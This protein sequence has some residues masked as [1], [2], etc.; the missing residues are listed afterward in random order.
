MSAIKS[1]TSLSSQVLINRKVKWMEI[2]TSPPEI[3]A[4]LKS[5]ALPETILARHSDSICTGAFCFVA[6]RLQVYC[7]A[8]ASAFVPGCDVKKNNPFASLERMYFSLIV[9][10]ETFI[11]VT[12]SRAAVPAKIVASRILQ[13]SLVAAVSFTLEATVNVPDA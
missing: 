7:N 12:K 10:W 1:E 13:L 3:T 4:E 2:E 6:V 5:A 8:S 11:V 9:R